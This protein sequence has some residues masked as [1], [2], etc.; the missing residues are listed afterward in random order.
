[1]LRQIAL[2][3]VLCAGLAVPAQGQQ[4]EPDSVSTAQAEHLRQD[5]QIR[6]RAA[7]RERAVAGYFFAS[8]V[9]G[10]T[11]GFFLP[12]GLAVPDGTSLALGSAGTAVVVASTSMA[13]NRDS[14]PPPA[15]LNPLADQPPEYQQAFRSAYAEQL[16]RRSVRA[17]LWGGGIGAGLGLGTLVWLVSQIEEF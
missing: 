16:R 2:S 6:G 10:L 15:V 5:A 12:L 13:A 9:G 11:T 8:F 1:M 17:S 14:R 3:L 4:V 7:A